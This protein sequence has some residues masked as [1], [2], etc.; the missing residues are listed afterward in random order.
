MVERRRAGWS[1]DDARDTA[2]MD[3]LLRA[4]SDALSGLLGGV[5]TAVWQAITGVVAS[6]GAAL[7]SGALAVIVVGLALLGLLWA[8]RR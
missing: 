2:A 4:I 1:L 8:L 5:L 7:P 6:L 3:G